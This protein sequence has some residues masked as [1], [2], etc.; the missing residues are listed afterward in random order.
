MRPGRLFGGTTEPIGSPPGGELAGHRARLVGR[1]SRG[2]HWFSE[3][4][5][6]DG[7]SKD[8]QPFADSPRPSQCLR[9]ARRRQ[10]CL[11]V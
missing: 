6:R 8:Q 11:L 7:R 2:G 9:A 3:I 10:R 5:L 4:S 1:V